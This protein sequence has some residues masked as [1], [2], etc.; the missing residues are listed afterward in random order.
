MDRTPENPLKRERQECNALS[1]M[2][3]FIA[4]EIYKLA[5]LKQY[6]DQY[7]LIY[8]LSKHIWEQFSPLLDQGFDS[9]LE[10][11]SCDLVDLIVY[12]ASKADFEERVSRVL[13]EPDVL[14]LGLEAKT[15]SDGEEKLEG[16]DEPFDYERHERELKQAAF[17]LAKGIFKK[18]RGFKT[19]IPHKYP[20]SVIG[21]TFDYYDA[22]SYYYGLFFISQSNK[23]G[24]EHT[25]YLAPYKSMRPYDERLIHESKGITREFTV[26]DTAL[27]RSKLQY[28][29]CKE[30][31]PAYYSVSYFIQ[32][33]PL[34]AVSKTSEMRFRIDLSTPISDVELEKALA[35]L[36]AQISIAQN[37]NRI[38][39]MLLAEN[40]ADLV[41]AHNTPKLE[42]IDCTEFMRLHKVQLPELNSHHHAKAYLCGLIV[43]FEH[44][45]RITTT[46]DSVTFSWG[47]NSDGLSREVRFG[48]VSEKLS[49]AHGSKGFS[50]STIEDGYKLVKTVFNHHIQ[51][52]R[53]GR[54]QFDA[55]LNTKQRDKLRE[56]MPVRLERLHKDDVD[57][58]K[59]LIT[60]HR[61]QGREA[62]VKPHPNGSYV[63][64][65]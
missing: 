43:L 51:D 64:T 65:W 18:N 22:L 20:P 42:P 35:D 3:N 7:S 39:D 49:K 26:P 60:Q 48:D 6:P 15:Y 59:S 16:N 1:E 53:F 37:H 19:S 54:V 34:E 14:Q 47:K 33:P 40:E 10:S 63:I 24:T 61:K 8:N 9:M 38:A 2:T 30:A 23:D 28:A 4:Q 27:S 13:Q 55:R 44:Y 46:G 17:Q 56:V 45:V 36:R 50:A 12:G 57:K 62:E 58:A 52:F 11:L 29:S 32:E 5:L 31:L 25:F 21:Y 41:K